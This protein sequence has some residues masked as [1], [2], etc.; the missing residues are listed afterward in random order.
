[1]YIFSVFWY[2]NGVKITVQVRLD[3]ETIADM[4][5]DSLNPEIASL[6][7]GKTPIVNQ[8]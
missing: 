2:V 5:L 7:E 1:M 3:E 6:V 4:A 8:N